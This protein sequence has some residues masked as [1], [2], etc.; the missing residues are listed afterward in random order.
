MAQTMLWGEKGESLP[1]MSSSLEA[2]R[3]R[4]AC[5][6]LHSPM[7]GMTERNYR[8]R[9]WR[10]LLRGWWDAD[11]GPFCERLSLGDLGRDEDAILCLKS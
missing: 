6:L 11:F 1:A 10:T 7:Q 9:A 2:S 3:A 5:L 4:V 8:A